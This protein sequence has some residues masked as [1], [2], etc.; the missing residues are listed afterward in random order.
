MFPE[1]ETALGI[2]LRMGTQWNAREG[3]VIGM[4][5]QSLRWLMDLFGMDADHTALFDDLQ[6]MELAAR[7]TMNA[8]TR[9]R[10]P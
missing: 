4:N 5:Y 10:A 9:V 1:N 2:F 6:A 8:E 7:E 3:G